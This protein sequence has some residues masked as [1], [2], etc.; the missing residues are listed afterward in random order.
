[1]EGRVDSAELHIRLFG[2]IQINRDNAPLSG[3]LST[4][5]PALIAYLAVTNRTLQRDT[6]A[7]LLWGELPDAD[8]KNN[9]RQ[10]LSNVR[11]L[12]DPYV[13]ITRDSV[14][15]NPDAAITLDVAQFEAHLQA[16]RNRPSD[17]RAGHLQA[18][19]SLYLGDFLQGFHV[20]DAPDFEEW[21]LAQ[22]TR[23]HELALHALHMLTDFNLSKGQYGRAIDH[24]TRLLALD[25]WRE[26]AHRQLMLALAR[27]GQRSAALAQ[28][29]TCRRILDEELGVTPSAETTALF[30]RIRA[31]GDSPRHNLPPQATPFVGRREEVAQ[32]ETRLLLR[33][34]RLITLIGVGGTGKT[35][36][37]LQAARRAVDLGLFL[38]GVY[39]VSLAAIADA[40]LVPAAIAEAL[41]FSIDGQA[42]PGKRVIA[43]VAEQELLFVLDNCEHLLDMASWLSRLLQQAPG[44][45]LLLTSRERL[46]VQ[47]EWCVPVDGLDYPAEDDPDPQA[48]SA[49]QLFVARARA[50]QPGMVFNDSA[51]QCVAR[52]CRMVAGI[53][54]GIELAAASLQQHTCEAIAAG[55][56]HNIDFLATRYR[57]IAP[58][59][60]SLRAAFDQSWRLLAPVEQTAF[61]RLSVFVGDFDSAAAHA[62]GVSAHVL[63]SLTDK[64]LV[65]RSLDGRYALHDLLR[66]FA[67]ELL[68]ALPQ[69]AANVVQ[70]HA[71]YYL[72]WLNTQTPLLRG[73][74]QKEA[75]QAI[76]ADYDNVLAAWHT[77]IEQ[78]NGAMLEQAAEPF[79]YFYLLRSRLTEGVAA[80]EAARASVTER[81]LQ[82]LRL[83]VHLDNVIAKLLITLSRVIEARPYLERNLAIEAQTSMPELEAATRRYYGALLVSLGELDSADYQFERS[84]DLAHELGDN[85][86]EANTLIDWARLAFV[87]KKLDV[88]EERCRTGL[89]LAEK[90]GELL[91][92]A[93]FLTGLSIANREMGRLDVAQQYVERSLIVYAELD[94]TYGL[95]QGHLA[96]G[97]LLLLQKRFAEARSLFQM[98][99]EGSHRIGFRWGEADAYWRL[100]Q[101]AQGVGDEAEVVAAWR[102]ALEI[103]LAIQEAELIRDIIV[104]LKAAHAD[105]NP[106]ALD[107]LEWA[108][109]QNGAADY[110][111]SSEVN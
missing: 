43:Q 3:F 16:S 10:T 39:F 12:I 38:N 70:Q 18:A 50:V 35:R 9:L 60:R 59:H 34:S 108:R 48:S 101:A 84:R 67:G 78:Q 17:E 62:I 97:A 20:R 1:M 88:C 32:I 42:D 92:I 81:D 40:A 94:D 95:I 65:R 29:K 64:S 30:Q 49:Y 44:V 86:A 57:D 22:R 87:R 28:Y 19:V 83:A 6:L 56:A 61:G 25:A 51:V 54:L 53:P 68:A 24:A 100:G 66:Q 69:D 107:L 89:A 8:A 11:K 13:L 76:S 31:A 71:A 41:G 36:L 103:A 96:L 21:A 47:W 85:W 74:E 2:G 72:H 26:E 27:S 7:T 79:Y 105:R 110:L 90:S 15:L 58:R 111:Q 93:N 104:D 91:L 99:L 33:E 106:F 102:E 46:N 4:K 75:L 109:H 23:L 5:V 80:F 63:A 77:A 98:A 14:G 37:A 45:K 73:R 82:S 52:I 55:I